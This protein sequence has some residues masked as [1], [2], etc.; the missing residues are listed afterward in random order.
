MYPFYDGYSWESWQKEMNY[1]P[2]SEY[3]KWIYSRSK[4]HRKPQKTKHK[5]YRKFKNGKRL[6][7]A[8][9]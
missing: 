6:K 3:A 7:K 1:T 5:K 9:K 8:F 4:K 2:L